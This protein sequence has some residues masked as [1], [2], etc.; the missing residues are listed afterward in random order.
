MS[1]T[2]FTMRHFENIHIPLWLLKDTCW[3]LEW[4]WLGMAMIL[5]TIGVATY[6]AVK[7]KG[8]RQMWL[9]WAICFW[10]SAN[11]YWMCAEFLD[12]EAL[13]YYAGIPFGI[14][15]IFTGIFYLSKAKP[16]DA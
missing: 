6:I 16:H 12:H 9:N 11:A 4:R 15:F 14:G 10:I 7:S 1:Q 5:P 2:R 8:F 13:K 3:M